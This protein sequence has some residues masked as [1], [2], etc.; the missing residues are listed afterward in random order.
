M[1]RFA[2]TVTAVIAAASL[3]SCEKP[4]TQLILVVD[5]DLRV[6]DAIDSVHIRVIDPTGVPTNQTVALAG[7]SCRCRSAW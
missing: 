3:A 5:T 4:I 6:P 2:L 1:R 7:E